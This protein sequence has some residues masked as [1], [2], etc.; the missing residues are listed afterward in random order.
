[1]FK[2]IQIWCCGVL[3][4]ENIGSHLETRKSITGGGSV[5]NV[6]K[7]CDSFILYATVENIDLSVL[8]EMNEWIESESIVIK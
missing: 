1:M 3:L 5:N 6:K 4:Q 2:I 7:M 8:K